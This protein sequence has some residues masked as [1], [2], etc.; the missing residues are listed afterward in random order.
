M[1]SPRRLKKKAKKVSQQQLSASFQPGQKN[2]IRQETPQV[3]I[4]TGSQ[5]GN[6]DL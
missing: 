1:T 2:K 3:N 6:Q 4:S 5:D